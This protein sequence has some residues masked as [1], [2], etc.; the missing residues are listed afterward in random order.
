MP[1]KTTGSLAVQD[2]LNGIDYRI[3]LNPKRINT[4]LSKEILD[5]LVEYYYDAYNKDFVALSNIYVTN[6]EAIPVLSKVN[7]YGQLRFGSKIFRSS[8]SKKHI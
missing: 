8:Y 5:L 6:S 2:E 7:I 3:F 4:N 1:K